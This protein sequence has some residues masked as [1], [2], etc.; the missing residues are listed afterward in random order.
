MVSGGDSASQTLRERGWG[1]EGA[2]GFWLLRAI[3]FGKEDDRSFR[4]RGDRVLVAGG[5]CS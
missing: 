2:I 5:D 3:G 4:G 1:K